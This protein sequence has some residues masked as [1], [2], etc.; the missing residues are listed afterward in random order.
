MNRKLVSHIVQFWGDIYGTANKSGQN[1][2][3]KD[4]E[5]QGN[6]RALVTNLSPRFNKKGLNSVNI[7]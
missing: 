5:N 7:P 1:T 3:K 6:L 2:F 4:T